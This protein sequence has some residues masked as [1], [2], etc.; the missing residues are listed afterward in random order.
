MRK[1]NIP[2]LSLS[3]IKGIINGNINS[4]VLLLSHYDRLIHKYCTKQLKDT[5]GN[6]YNFFDEDK[7]QDIRIKLY[8]NVGK[9]KI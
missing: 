4:M 3:V 1:N 6:V 2:L 9:F 5:E 7:Y 8:K